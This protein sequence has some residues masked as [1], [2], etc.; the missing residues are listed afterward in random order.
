[1]I[2]AESRTLKL[3]RNLRSA[4]DL[5]TPR[6]RAS[7]HVRIPLR[8]SLGVFANEMYMVED[9]LDTTHDD[10]PPGI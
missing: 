4:P 2:E 9:D 5:S 6:D 1:M 10:F 3:H 7:Q 8:G